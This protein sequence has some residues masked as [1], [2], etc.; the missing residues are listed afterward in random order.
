M[1]DNKK[2]QSSYTKL[3]RVV[4]VLCVVLLLA[5]YLVTLVAAITTSPKAPALFRMSLGSTLVLPILFW[6]Y[7]S[8][9]RYFIERDRKK[10][11]MALG[12]MEEADKKEVPEREGE[13]VK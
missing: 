7:I 13:K 9:V 12:H 2:T 10:L 5:L 4:A 3:Q 8:I 1:K 6:F 11:D